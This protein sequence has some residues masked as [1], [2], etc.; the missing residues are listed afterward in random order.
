MLRQGAP[1]LAVAYLDLTP[2]SP[3]PACGISDKMQV[4]FE[5]MMW[6]SPS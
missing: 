1:C 6:Q 3:P 4:S 5:P 2:V